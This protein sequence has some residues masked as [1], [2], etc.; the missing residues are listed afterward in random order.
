MAQDMAVRYQVG[1]SS[2]TAGV[3]A[4]EVLEVRSSKGLYFQRGPSA[5]P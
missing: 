1:Y 4:P 5:K 2:E 3:G